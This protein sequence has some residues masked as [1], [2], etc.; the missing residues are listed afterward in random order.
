[1]EAL[2]GQ[3]ENQIQSENKTQNED[4]DNVKLVQIPSL[5]EFGELLDIVLPP[6]SNGVFWKHMSIYY[7]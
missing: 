2:L 7:C 6:S 3:I 4:I 5:G 1:M